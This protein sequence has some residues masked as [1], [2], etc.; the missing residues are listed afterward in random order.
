MLK[1]AINN[2]LP[3]LLAGLLMTNV[4]V[5]PTSSQAAQ[6]LDRVV[7][8]VNEDVISYSELSQKAKSVELRLRKLQ[9]NLPAKDEFNAQV[10]E[11]MVLDQI[12]MQ[13][14]NMVGIEVDDIALND[15][16]REIAAQEGMTLGQMRESLRG[17]EFSFAEFRNSV[18]TELTVSKLQQREIGHDI[19]ISKSELASFLNSPAGQDQTGMEYHLGHILLA[20]PDSPT[21]QQIKRKQQQAQAIIN[22]LAKGK[23]SFATLAIAQSQ[24]Q[25][26]LQGG[27][28]G[29][30]KMNEL[31]TLFVKHIPNMQSQDIVGPLRSPSGLHIIKLI[32]KRLGKQKLTSEMH[33]RHIL[34]KPSKKLSAK[35]AERKLLKVYNQANKGQNFGELA[36]KY[37]EEINTAPNGGDLGWVTQSSVLPEFYR[38]IGKLKSGEISKPFATKLGWHLVQ[39]VERRNQQSSTIAARN[40]AMDIIHRRKFNAAL[41][42]WLA[43]IREDAHVEILL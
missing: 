18:Q 21:T 40:K 12:Q 29:W 31:P 8:V 43:R 4:L 10:L 7:A 2:C 13:M 24:G 23:A 17:E 25:H 19:N 15:A 1:N 33:L 3:S 41:T 26:A 20:L 5:F 27:E 36:V 11:K 6:S 42:N 38:Q 9:V 22:K 28:L 16:I 30:R 34:I 35:D 37:S 32:D 39:L 14:A